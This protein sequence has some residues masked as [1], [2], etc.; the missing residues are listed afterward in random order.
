MLKVFSRQLLKQQGVRMGMRL[1]VRSRV[2]YVT[3]NPHITHFSTD[4]SAHRSLSRLEFT[5]T[6]SRN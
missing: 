1:G 5:L 3:L 6:D 2:C 4:F